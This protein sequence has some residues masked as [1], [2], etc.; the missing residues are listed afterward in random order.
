MNRLLLAVMFFFIPPQSNR[1]LR[2]GVGLE[3]GTMELGNGSTVNAVIG[4]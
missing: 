2:G 3:D 4:P 1:S